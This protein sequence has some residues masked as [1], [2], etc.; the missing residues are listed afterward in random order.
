ML[1]PLIDVQDDERVFLED[2]TINEFFERDEALR[3]TFEYEKN[4]QKRNDQAKS[5]NRKRYQSN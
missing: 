2:G 3:Q 1:Q 5:R 4:L